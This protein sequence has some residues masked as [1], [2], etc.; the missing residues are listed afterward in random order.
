MQVYSRLAPAVAWHQL[1]VCLP[2]GKEELGAAPAFCRLLAMANTSASIKM[3]V[4]VMMRAISVVLTRLD[5]PSTVESS[6]G[7]IVVRNLNVSALQC[8]ANTA[9]N[10]MPGK[11]MHM[12]ATATH[13]T[14]LYRA[15]YTL[16]RVRLQE[17]QTS[18]EKMIDPVEHGTKGQPIGN[19]GNC[20]HAC[21]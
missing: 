6:T 4:A 7:A 18:S 16:C 13:G 19:Q 12:A 2:H 20:F 21:T 5:T 14:L 3:K 11:Y 9:H 1:L 10:T 8:K 15:A 17:Q